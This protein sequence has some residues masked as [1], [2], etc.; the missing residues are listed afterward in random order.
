MK[1]VE[2]ENITDVDVTL[3]TS[4]LEISPLN[5]GDCENMVCVFLTFDVF[6]NEMSPL[7]E[8]KS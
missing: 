2:P 3:D 1:A 5:V 7:N 6:Q 4:Q 8:G